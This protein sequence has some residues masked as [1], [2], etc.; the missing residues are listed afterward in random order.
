ML[1][2]EIKKCLQITEALRPPVMTR[3]QQLIMDLKETPYTSYWNAQLGKGADP[4]PGLPAGM[5]PVHTTFGQP[6]NRGIPLKELVNPS[7]SYYEVLKESQKGHDMYK[8]THNDYNPSEK[9]DR[10]YFNTINKANKLLS[11]F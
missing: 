7:K 3:Y 1:E 2:L 5:D 6:T 4:T 11:N 10:R 8:K 9:V